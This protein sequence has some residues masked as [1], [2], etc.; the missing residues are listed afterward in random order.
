MKNINS[1]IPEKYFNNDYLMVCNGIYRYG[2]QYVTSI[3]FEQE[4]EYEEGLNASDISQYPL[5]D[6]LDKYGV[7]INDFYPELN[8]VDSKV[9]YLEFASEEL[10]NLEHLQNIISRHVY[11]KTI[12][13]NGKSYIE[14]IIE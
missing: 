4:P 7:Y 2:T 1:F 13:S 8:T 11:N 9:C 3:S 14:L 10:S 5:E 6:L 12:K